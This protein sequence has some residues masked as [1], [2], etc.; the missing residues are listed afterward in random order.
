MSIT[1]TL[2]AVIKGKGYITKI[3]K[4]RQIPLIHVKK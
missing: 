1:K 4:V 2:K 3:D